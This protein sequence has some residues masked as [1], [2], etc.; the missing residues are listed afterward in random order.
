MRV[1]GGLLL[2]ELRIL[3]EDDDDDDID[4]GY[5]NELG[6]EVLVSS[7][8][9]FSKPRSL[10]PNCGESGNFSDRVEKLEGF[11]D[12]VTEGVLILLGFIR[13]GECGVS[14]RLMDEMAAHRLIRSWSRTDFKFCEGT[15]RTWAV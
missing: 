6:C 4:E 7:A 13:F 11:A 14:F 8:P 2:L 1:A 15:P 3:P 10:N 9:L 12:T 5:L